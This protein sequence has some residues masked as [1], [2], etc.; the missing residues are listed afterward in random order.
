MSIGEDAGR[1]PFTPPRAEMRE[2]RTLSL[3]LLAVVATAVVIGIRLAF[4]GQVRF[5][6]GADACFYFALAREIASRHDFLLNFVWNYQ[7]DQ[8][9]LPSLAADYWRPGTSLLLLLAVPFG[10][11]TLR[12][13]AILATAATLLMALAAADF[14]WSLTRRPRTTLLAYVIGLCLP[15][16]WVIAL[17][18]D[19]NV[20]YGA[21]ISWFLA[22]FLPTRRSVARDALAIVCLAAAYMI[23]NDAILLVVPFAAVLAQRVIDR[24]RAGVAGRGYTLALVVAFVLALVPTHL[25]IRYMTGHFS[26]GSIFSVLF[27]RDLTDFSRY[28]DRLDFAT[29]WAAGPATLVKER[30]S[31]LVQMLHH[32]LMRF[33]EAATMLA[34]VGAAVGAIVRPRADFVRTVIGP[35]AFL[36][37]LVLVYGLVL[38]GIGDH[39]AQRSYTALL[40]IVAALAASGIE[41]IAPSRAA[42]LALA[43]AAIGFSAVDGVN[44]AR[45]ALDDGRKEQAQYDA[46]AHFIRGATPDPAAALAMV[47]NP[48][49]FT[50]ATGIPSVSLPTNGPAAV[51]QA[52][53]DFKATAIVTDRWSDVLRNDK[54]L[55]AAPKQDAPDS[56]LVVISLTPTFKDHWD[57]P[58]GRSG[59]AAT[60]STS[61]AAHLQCKDGQRRVPPCPRVGPD[62]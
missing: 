58:P 46:E 36:L 60:R 56:R 61:G 37:S 59:S 14:A 26:S 15:T 34:F 8:V 4:A 28:G 25:L 3:V 53:R 6:G 24:R 7:V 13:D 20:F 23:R 10:E 48:A 49:V 29:W 52:A 42:W 51:R 19:S 38:P 27:I 12:S 21:A 45:V 32:L 18:A 40:P 11:I 33:G 39:S 30:A 62:K 5:C 54:E 55:A 41:E 57:A 2:R 1:A 47:A 22:L 9:V 17:Q 43:I 35:A 50:T 44:R 31:V 16:L